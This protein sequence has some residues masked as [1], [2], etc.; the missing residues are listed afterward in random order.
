VIR[1]E[2]R[3]VQIDAEL[4]RLPRWLTWNNP[5][6][7]KLAQVSYAERILPAGTLDI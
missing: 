1:D 3:R 5:A 6:V 2:W 7:K 4:L